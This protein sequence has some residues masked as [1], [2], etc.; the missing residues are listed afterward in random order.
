MSSQ[1]EPQAVEV[2]AAGGVV[3][4][5]GPD[6]RLQ[7]LV[8]HRP[9]YDDWSLPKGKLDPGESWHH[10]AVREVHEETGVTARLGV[11][12][13]PTHYTDRRG[14]LKRVRW[15]TMPVLAQEP[16][17]P[18]DEVD[19]RR[20][21]NAD[22]VGALLT[23]DGDRD[24]VDE[25]MDA[26]DHATVLVVRHTHAGDRPSWNG[27]DHLR[28]LSA[29]GRGQADALV[30]HLAPWQVTRII[31]SPLVR[32]VQTV[33]PLAA[34]LDLAVETDARL[35]EGASALQTQSLLRECM[36]GTVLCS[37]GDVIGSLVQDLADRGIVHRDGMEWEK[38][39]TWALRLDGQRRAVEAAYVTPPA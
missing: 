26:S 5:P 12:L 9:A 3:M 1:A 21:V 14:R 15:W 4:R 23:Y 38:G 19:E 36:P 39:S 29:F 16:R 34:A 13:T 10:A 30:A 2:R 11:E 17:D 37:H 25:A 20:W 33:E 6:G 8:V 35:A 28:P 22:A 18:D 32:C 24:L 31:T 27:N 7:V